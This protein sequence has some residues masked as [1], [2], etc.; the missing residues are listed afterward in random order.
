MTICKDCFF[1]IDEVCTCTFPE[2]VS[3]NN[4]HCTAKQEVRLLRKKEVEELREKYE[5]HLTHSRDTFKCN[6]IRNLIVT[7]E[8]LQNGIKEWE[9]AYVNKPIGTRKAMEETISNMFSWLEDNNRVIF[10]KGSKEDVIK[11]LAD[12]S[13]FFDAL[14]EKLEDYI[15]SMGANYGIEIE[16]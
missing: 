12:D 13:D 9:E 5:N 3:M 14:L 4:E 16:E 2:G 8:I 11:E 6:D 1:R 15:D 7:I 10:T